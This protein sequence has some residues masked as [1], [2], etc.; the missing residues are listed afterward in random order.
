MTT[1]TEIMQQILT[2]QMEAIHQN[3]GFL[4]LEGQGY[5]TTTSDGKLIIVDVMPGRAR[6]QLL[7]DA[8][9]EWLAEWEVK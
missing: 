9:G 5:L 2:G 6:I 7:D 4:G 1:F 8:T 3:P